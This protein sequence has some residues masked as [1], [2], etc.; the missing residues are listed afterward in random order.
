M[1]IFQVVSSMSENCP[2]PIANRNCSTLNFTYIVSKSLH[3][4]VLLVEPH[5]TYTWQVAPMPLS[6][7]TAENTEDKWIV[8]KDRLTTDTGYYCEIFFI[9]FF[10]STFFL[11]RYKELIIFNV[12]THWD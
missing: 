10:P 11:E 2:Q 9:L 12:F 7:S 5:M 4:P 6:K 1:D 3:I 8:T